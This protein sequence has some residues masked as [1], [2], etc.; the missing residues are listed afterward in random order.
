MSEEKKVSNRWSKIKNWPKTVNWDNV[1]K[2]TKDIAICVGMSALGWVVVEHISSYSYSDA[3]FGRQDKD[4]KE[5]L[6]EKTDSVKTAL[7]DSVAIRAFIEKT[8]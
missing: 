4:R 3:L 1:K 2:E 7:P 6:V 5:T 8:R